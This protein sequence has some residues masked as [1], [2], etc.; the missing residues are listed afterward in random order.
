MASVPQS[1]AE[2]SHRENVLKDAKLRDPHWL[3]SSD[4]TEYYRIGSS[5]PAD[6]FKTDYRGVWIV[7]DESPETETVAPFILAAEWLNANCRAPGEKCWY[8][9]WFT[10]GDVFQDSES[11]GSA[12]GS[13]CW[14]E[15]WSIRVGTE[16][17]AEIL[18]LPV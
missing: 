13:G 18:R 5:L 16:E 1:P 15:P 2:G 9:R 14:V 6:S 7:V 8:A 11:L 3:Y 12:N 17:V 4:A 10:S